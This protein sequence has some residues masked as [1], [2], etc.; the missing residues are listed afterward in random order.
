MIYVG[1]CYI[2]T[3]NALKYSVV[4]RFILE[5]LFSP[6][7]NA[8]NKPLQ[9][10]NNY[11]RSAILFL[12]YDTLFLVASFVEPNYITSGLNS[13]SWATNFLKNHFLIH[14]TQTEGKLSD[15]FVRF[16]TALTIP[17]PSRVHLNFV[18]GF[19]PS[20]SGKLRKQSKKWYFVA[21]FITRV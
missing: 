2:F 15:N 13:V 20:N 6:R 1:L 19:S 14:A 9:A 7:R 21:H 8:R 16:H 12:F 11:R 17:T 10:T 3:H 18:A 5:C 4:M